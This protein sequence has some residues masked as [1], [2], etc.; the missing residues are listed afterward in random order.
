MRVQN[1]LLCRFFSIVLVSQFHLV[2]TIQADENIGLEIAKTMKSRE[3]GFDNYKAEMKMVLV[4][5]GGKETVRLLRV[6][7]R[8]KLGD[9][10]QSIAVF[11][12]PADLKGT[13]FLSYTH[14][15]KDD[16]QWLYLPA[17]KR[18][19]RIAVRNKTSPFM[20]SEFSYED[21]ASTEVKKYTY[22]YVGEDNI[23]DQPSFVIE[24]F[25]N[26][27]YSGY[28]KHK[29]WVEKERYIPL[30]IEYF[31]LKNN[32]RK[33]LLNTHYKLHLDRFWRAHE[34]HMQNHISKKSS[35]LHWN[36]FKFRQ[37]MSEVDFDPKRLKRIR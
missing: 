3:S 14:I 34:M 32:L 29:V 11:D 7:T 31:D 28:S 23:N 5:S 26:D 13:A 30:K 37:P 6:K 17:L 33:T 36:Q 19:K 1:S 8:E 25:P 35:V 21:L 10:N 12:K 22:Q 2:S 4:D 24:R 16:D 15:N 20:G 18:V 9:G 27:P